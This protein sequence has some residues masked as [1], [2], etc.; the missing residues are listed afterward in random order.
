M[1]TWA[2]VVSQRQ[3]Q[4]QQRHVRQLGEIIL[5][6]YTE[7]YQGTQVLVLAFSNDVD[8]IEERKR[9][10]ITVNLRVVGYEGGLLMVHGEM[11]VALCIR[12]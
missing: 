12:L 2:P 4:C 3:C 6:V 5:G 10:S 1:C 7:A 11:K 9:T 8:L